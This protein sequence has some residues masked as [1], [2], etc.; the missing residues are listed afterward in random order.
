[1]IT[2][3]CPPIYTYPSIHYKKIDMPK[4]NSVGL[5]RS[6]PPPLFSILHEQG[7]DW[8]HGE[9]TNEIAVV[10]NNNRKT[11]IWGKQFSYYLA[12]PEDQR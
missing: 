5:I 8:C 6:P 4:K 12:F 9:W 11:S 1:M 3:L 10:R 7:E 2:Q